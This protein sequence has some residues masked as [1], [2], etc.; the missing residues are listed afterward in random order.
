[1]NR[2]PS[3]IDVAD[4]RQGAVLARRDE[5]LARRERGGRG[6]GV[7]EGVEERLVLEGRP[8]LDGGIG[9]Q[10]EERGVLV[11]VAAG[12]DALG[13]GDRRQ[14]VPD[15]RQ[16]GRHLGVVVSV[17]LGRV[18]VEPVGEGLA[19]ERAEVAVQRRVLLGQR[20]DDG[21]VRQRLAP[22]PVIHIAVVA[23]RERVRG[24]ERDP[25]V[26]GRR[27]RALQEAVHLPVV[28]LNQPAF[29]AVVG[30]AVPA[31][32]EVGRERVVGVGVAVDRG[33]VLQVVP[34]VG[35]GQPA[36]EVVERA[37][38][39]HQDDDVLDAPGTVGANRG[40]GV[41]DSLAEQVGAGD[42]K[43]GGNG[44]D[45]EELTAIKHHPT[46]RL[47][48][49]QQVKIKSTTIDIERTRP[50][51][52]RPLIAVGCDGLSLGFSLRW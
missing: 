30:V 16:R 7:R 42:R 41:G 45:L 1:M 3:R 29:P 24:G 46:L 13:V 12:G 51:L 36:E 15:R 32:L 21:Q 37:V 10:G 2:S 18:L 50:A 17:G 14:L 11:V 27:R 48:G 35:A 52:P 23:D 31:A 47:E 38:L 34:P 33:D 9:P 44:R 39:H 19:R 28:V 25:R 6:V 49:R 8:R 22:A 5:R 43:A 26:V 20:A 40:R 4:V